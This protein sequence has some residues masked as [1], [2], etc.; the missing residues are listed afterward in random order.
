MIL[1]LYYNSDLIGKIISIIIIFYSILIIH[2]DIYDYDKLYQILPST[3]LNKNNSYKN[4]TDIFESRLLYIDNTNL[5]KEYIHFIRP[6]KGK[7]LNA[8]NPES[9][10]KYF[11]I[12]KIEQI[13]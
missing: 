4:L 6:L 2:P 12:L 13:N 7:K 1:Y 3:N 8:I 10:K 9:L 5:T 11:I